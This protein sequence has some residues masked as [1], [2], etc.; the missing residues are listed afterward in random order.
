[1]I[2]AGRS[3]EASALALGSVLASGLKLLSVDPRVG[4]VQLR[5]TFEG[6]G[7]D[8]AHKMDRYR[9]EEHT[10]ELQSLV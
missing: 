5:Q 10:S 6:A 7:R 4:E 9:S 2:S 1:M 3:R 8:A